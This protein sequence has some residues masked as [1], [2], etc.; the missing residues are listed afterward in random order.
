MTE[1]EKYKQALDVACSLMNGDVFY[2]YDANRIFSEVMDKKG[3]FCSCDYAD[4]ILDNLDFFL[5]GN[6][7]GMKDEY[8]III[9][10]EDG[11]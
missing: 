3:V 9:R 6:P 4:V 10:D 2:G 7:E 8:K 1:L 5:H 11:V